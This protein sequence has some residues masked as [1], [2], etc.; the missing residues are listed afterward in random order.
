M[1]SRITQAVVDLEAATARLLEAAGADPSSLLEG[2]TAR[3]LAV[4]R[5][6]H[7][8]HESGLEL[9]PGNLS[10]IKSCQESGNLL[11]RR[12]LAGRAAIRSELTRLSENDHLLRAL[13]QD[14]LAGL[15]I[16]T[17]G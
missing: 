3:S 12:L 17:R 5:L 8:L 10:R 4:E 13:P 2:M 9:S 11:H 16:D 7:E 1:P 15:R 6:R 14:K